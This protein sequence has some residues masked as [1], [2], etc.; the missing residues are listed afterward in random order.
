MTITANWIKASTIPVYVPS[1][2][3]HS[4]T[5]TEPPKDTEADIPELSITG[6]QGARNQ[7]ALSWN[8]VPGA[9]NFSL[10]VK[11]G[12]KYAFVQD[13]GTSTAVDVVRSTSGKYYVSTGGDYNIYEYDET[14]ETFIRVGTLKASSIDDVVKANN[15]TNNFMIKYKVNGKESAEKDSYKVSVKI[16]YKPA[17]KATVKDGKVTIK[18]AKVE[19]ATMYRVMKKTSS[20]YKLVTETEKNSVRISKVKSGKYTYAVQALVDGEWTKVYKS[21]L[22]SVTAE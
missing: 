1:T 7:S 4:P 20:G 5:W 15:V 16:Y 13:L 19:G 11:I 6:V 10:Y 21:D 14:T 12:G 8:N 22:A 2:V 18:W 9:T 3:S 17:P